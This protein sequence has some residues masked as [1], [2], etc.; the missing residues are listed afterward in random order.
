M[1]STEV[2]FFRAAG[3]YLCTLWKI[4]FCESCGTLDCWIHAGGTFY[5]TLGTG[6]SQGCLSTLWETWETRG[7]EESVQ[8]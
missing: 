3:C 6:F 5:Y 4:G 2:L 1:G 8:P 7:D